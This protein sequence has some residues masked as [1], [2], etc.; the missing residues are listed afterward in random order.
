MNEERLRQKTTEILEEVNSCVA[1]D[2][3]NCVLTHNGKKGQKKAYSDID[4]AILKKVG[5]VYVYMKKDVCLYVGK[6]RNL[7]W[8]IKDHYRESY[9][10][11]KP[12]DRGKR[13]YDFFGAREN[14]GDMRI[15]WKP[16]EDRK[17]KV[18]EQMLSYVLEPEFE[19]EGIQRENE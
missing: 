8:R 13:W 18:V 2:W 14:Q 12:K 15:F 19:K 5:G 4:G 16:M 17:A 3:K 11:P 9:A 10:K 1:G 6:S 7:N